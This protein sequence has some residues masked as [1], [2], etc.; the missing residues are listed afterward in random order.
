MANSTLIVVLAGMMMSSV[1]AA[2]VLVV[3]LLWLRNRPA[4]EDT[5][6]PVDTP[7]PGDGGG[8]WKKATATFYHSYPEC[9]EGGPTYRP[10]ADRTEC[11]EFSGCSYQGTFAALGKKDYAWVQKN[12]LASVFEVGQSDA[13]W[14]SKWAN[15]TLT[16]RNP[17]TGK[18]MDVL[19][20]D[21]CGDGDCGGCCTDNAKKNGGVLV[22]LEVHTAKRF[23]G[24]NVPGLSVLEWRLK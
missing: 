11:D 22:D 12:N 6:K 13:S 9:C 16:I 1:L 18:T 5:P 15:K 17:S 2:V 14:K 23:W 24:S 19:V 3:V 10:G 21:T 8:E 7:K 20:A 4:K